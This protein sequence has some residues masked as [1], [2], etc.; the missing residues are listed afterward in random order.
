MGRARHLDP[1]DGAVGH[2]AHVKA[3]RLEHDV[4]DPGLE[5]VGGDSPG[6][7]PDVAGVQHGGH[8]APGDAPAP[9]RALALAHD[10]GVAVHDRDPVDGDRELV[11]DD[12]GE[13]RLV[14]LAVG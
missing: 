14:P 4:V 3:A 7:L 5:E 12:L 13:A 11:G 2:P 6:L 10:P 1:A 9:V 8:A